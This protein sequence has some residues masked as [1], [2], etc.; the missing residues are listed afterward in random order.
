MREKELRL[1]LVCYGG[2][3]LAVYMHGVTKEFWHLAR[4]SRAVLDNDSD[5]LG[6]VEQHYA[7]LI[8]D[9]SQRAG[10]SLRIL[11]D[12]IA[13]ASAGGI[14]GIFLGHALTTG[15]SLDPLTTLWLETADVDTLLDPDARPISRFTKFWATPLVWLALKRPGNAIARTVSLDARDE[16]RH[17]LSRFVRARWFEPPFGGGVFSSLLLDAFNAM[18]KGPR[19][20]KLV[21]PGQPLDLFVTVT[22]FHGHKE[23]LKLN[24]PSEIT[25]TEHKLIVSF[26]DDGNT[27]N[28]LDDAIALTFAARATASF[29]GAFPPFSVTELDKV[30]SA[31]AMA[32]PGRD[33][34]LARTLPHKDAAQAVLIDGSV[35]ANAPFK[36]AIAALR[37]RPARREVDRRF[38]YIDP[39][40]GVRSVRLTPSGEAALPGF[41][42]TI[43]GAMSDIPREQPIRDSLEAIEGRSSRI[44]RMLRIIE[45]LRPGVEETIDRLFGRT[46][47]LDSPTQ[48]R[49][50]SWR[51]K[52]HTSATAA[53]G[54]SYAGY[55]HVKLSSIV[56]D[57]AAITGN[58]R[59]DLRADLAR[60]QI[61]AILREQGIDQIGTTGKLTDA[62]IM[63][64]R[65]HDIG[66]RVRRLRFVLR[67]IT[68][69]IQDGAPHDDLEDIRA[70]IYARLSPLLER[71]SASF[72]TLPSDCAAADAV[73]AI[74][75]QRDL[76]RL[77]D[78]TDLSL[79]AELAGVPKAHR[80]PILLAYL[81][82]PYFD[83]STFPMLQ[84]EGLDE[85]D[86]I[87]VDR[88]SPDD[89]TSIRK[90]GTLATL[91][92]VE[93]NSF[94]AFFSRLY[95]ENDYLWGRL[96]GVE[97]LMD[98]LISTID[99]ASQPTPTEVIEIKRKAFMAVVEEEEPRLLH[100]VPQ[101]AT[102]RQEI[103][104]MASGV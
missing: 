42:S 43:F 100:I 73:E 4:A 5:S 25:E 104:A 35:L 2:I 53:A 29:P 15:L 85:F 77:D 55:T 64:L 63:F 17:K 103:A 87:K 3:S 70:T 61:W 23:R 101:I 50:K 75:K 80:R 22:D 48:A 81:G 92:G 98:I 40:P 20:P 78:E 7:A 30:V 36:P 21:P 99:P 44:R 72:Y 19:G 33:S 97:R 1:A 8:A 76:A 10:T 82:F 47:F 18:A 34:F 86:P 28:E 62:T 65:T 57:M 58:C 74:A 12:I 31:R 88:I 26:R 67:A 79:S 24:S 6:K 56:E 45:A 89:A 41:F 49:I 52:V 16:V 54:F 68:R 13:G 39:K 69:L 14:N 96:H 91:K 11:P 93:F 46:F 102:I 83:I 38:I 94:G 32:W 60:H 66:F 59:A 37:D 90:G 51:G 71:E 27:R 95:R 84:G 9:I